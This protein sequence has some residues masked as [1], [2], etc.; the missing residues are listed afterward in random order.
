MVRYTLRRIFITIPIL[1]VM[2]VLTFI[3]ARAVASPESALRFN[4]RVRAEDIARYREQ[5]GLDDSEFVQYTRWLG[6]FVTGDLGNSLVARR[7]VGEMLAEALRNTIVLAIVALAFS[8]LIGILVGIIAAVRQNSW[9]D[10]TT[11]GLSL[12]GIATPV[13]LVGLML[14]LVLGVYLQRWLNTSEPIFFT[15]GMTSPGT[16][17]FDLMDRLRHIALPALALGVQLV[18]IYSR[19][20]RAS[21]LEVLNSDYLRTARSKGISERRVLVKHGVRTALIPLTTQAAIDIGLLMG[22]LLI[23]EVIFAWPGMGTLFLQALFDG[24]YVVILPWL[25]I[26]AAA[27]FIFNLIADLLY[28]VLDPRI[29]YA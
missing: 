18:A 28:A 11:T 22:G 9:F 19:Y 14:Q 13:F 24:D 1:L 5:L 23:T 21:L 2:S 8:L 12:L 20:M 29:R 16:Q 17:G 26:T 4:P 15:A 7:G 27:V 3:G 6:K 25:M 10:Y